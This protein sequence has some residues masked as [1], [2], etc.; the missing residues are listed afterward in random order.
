MKKKLFEKFHASKKVD[1]IEAAK[2]ELKGD[3]PV[4]KLSKSIEGLHINAYY[5]ISDQAKA[6]KCNLPVSNDPYLGPRAW[7]NM[8]LVSVSEAKASNKTALAHLSAGAD[9]LVY[10]IRSRIDLNDLL[11]G[12]KLPYCSTLL[13]IDSEHSEILLELDEICTARGHDKSAIKGGVIWKS[14]PQDSNF[15]ETFQDWE[16]FFV[17][18]HSIPNVAPVESLVLAL[19]RGVRSID[20]L[21]ASNGAPTLTLAGQA[22]SFEIGNNFFFE[23]AKLKAFRRLWH[24][25]LSAYDAKIT[26]TPLPYVHTISTVWSNDAYNPNSNMLKATTSAIASILG[27]C[28]GMTILPQDQSHPVQSRIARN[29]SNILREESHMHRTADPTAGS[30]YL[31]ALIEQMAREAWEK[32]KESI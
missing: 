5:D 22:F 30:Y 8:P 1:W 11:D 32:F 15:L 18:G 21:T 7:H 24:T 4:A 12:I 16:N 14:A 2:T 29:T 10:D 23:I 25:V 27:G 31:E 20:A 3:D 6:L 28:D 9:G 13:M 17:L 26:R 19:Q